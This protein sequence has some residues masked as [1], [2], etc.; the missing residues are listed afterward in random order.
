GSSRRGPGVT[1][2]RRRRPSARAGPRAEGRG[3]RRRP[4]ETLPLSVDVAG[5]DA[6][7]PEFGLR[8]I[9]V[10]GGARPHR[11]GDLGVPAAARVAAQDAH[12][13]AGP[14]DAHERLALA[15]CGHEAVGVDAEAVAAR[16][17]AGGPRLR[18][19]EAGPADGELVEH[20]DER[21]G[22]VD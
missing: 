4:Q 6:G 18:T 21:A 5:A 11:R 10:G 20:L 15:V 9:R 3:L 22:V 14:S 2:P 7:E 19:G 17:P 1:V 16:A 8:E 13:P 12:A